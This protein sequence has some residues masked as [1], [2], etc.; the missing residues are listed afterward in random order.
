MGYGLIHFIVDTILKQIK[1]D[2]LPAMF[3]SFLLDWTFKLS[4]GSQPNLYRHVI[5]ILLCVFNV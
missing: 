2:K 4:G 5:Y 1:S 3:T